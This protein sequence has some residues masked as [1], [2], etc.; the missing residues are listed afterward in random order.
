FVP[1]WSHS[2]AFTT[3]AEGPHY[4]WV[5]TL[6]ATGLQPVTVSVSNQTR[7]LAADRERRQRCRRI[8]IERANRQRRDRKQYAAIELGWHRHGLGP[9]RAAQQPPA[10][11]AHAG[12]HL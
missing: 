7:A 5:K 2:E 10:V 1:S 4:V 9:Q 3:K 6:L 11:V 8:E 12:N